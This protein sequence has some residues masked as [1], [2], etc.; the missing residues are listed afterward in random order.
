VHVRVTCRRCAASHK[1]VQ[2]I[3]GS[4]L[5]LLAKDGLCRHKLQQVRNSQNGKLIK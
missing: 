1:H 5:L 4:L 2:E 3:P